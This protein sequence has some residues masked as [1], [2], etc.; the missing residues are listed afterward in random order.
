LLHR[1]D[2]RNQTSRTIR[3]TEAEAVAFVVCRAIGLDTNTASADYIRLYQG[4]S[5]TLS[6]SLHFI[7]STATEILTALG[8]GDC[9]PRAQV[10]A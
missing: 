3:E 10:E 8:V 6:A 5:A 9:T 2:R 1:D 7:Q 4:D